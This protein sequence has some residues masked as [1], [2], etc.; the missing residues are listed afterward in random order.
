MAVA[1]NLQAI[2]ALRQSKERL[3]LAQGAANSGTYEWNVRTDEVFWTP[4]METLYGLPVGAFAGH[5][6][7]GETFVHPDDLQ[8]VNA[9]LRAAVESRTG[10]RNE[11]RI[12]RPDGEIRWMEG[13][14]KVV[15]DGKGEPVRMIGLNRDIT[16]RTLGEEKRR[17]RE[18]E[19]A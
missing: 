17:T 14:G 2:E 6:G 16:D 8:A 3:S 13:V 4:E 10:F 18:P 11:F 15:C 9:V 19:L 12:I 5:Y 7:S 1:A